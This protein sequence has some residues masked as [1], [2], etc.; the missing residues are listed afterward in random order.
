MD[1]QID[2]GREEAVRIAL[3]DLNGRLSGGDQRMER[4]VIE[5]VETVPQKPDLRVVIFKN[6][7][8]SVTEPQ[9]NITVDI[10]EGK[11]VNFQFFG[12]A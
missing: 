10:N 4:K 12:G 5:S 8:P 6:R 7:R 9:V 3:A 1:T 11:V 2:P